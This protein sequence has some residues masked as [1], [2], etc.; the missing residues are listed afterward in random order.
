MVTIEKSLKQDE[1]KELQKK[2]YTGTREPT[3]KRAEPVLLISAISLTPIDAFA[4][5]EP[6]VPK[7]SSFDSEYEAALT[8]TQ[9]GKGKKKNKKKPQGFGFGKYG[10]GHKADEEEEPAFKPLEIMRAS[11]AP[12][13]VNQSVND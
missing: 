6:I 9:P 3:E 2:L 10:T 5:Y 7:C 1:Y 11:K 13:P 12:Q 4:G 8:K